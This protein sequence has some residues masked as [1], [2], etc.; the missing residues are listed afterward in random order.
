MSQG[1]NRTILQPGST[2]GVL[3]SGQLGRMFA[4]AA[5][6]LGYRILVFSPDSDSPTGQIA[7]HEFSCHYDDLERIREF[8][9]QVQVITF[10]FENV[11]AATTEA[12]AAIVPVRPSGHV[13]HVT[14][15]RLREK[16]FLET[17]SFPVTP[18]RRINSME[19][20]EKA[21]REVG[22]PAVL[23]TASFG[24]DGK[25]QQKI[26]ASSELPQ[27]F[28]NLRGA[29]GIYEGFVDFEKELS[30]IVARTLDG[31]T[32]TFPVFE[33]SHVNH[34]LDVT[35]APAAIEPPLAAQAR[36]LTCG[37]VE[38]LQV[39]GLLTVE[40]FLTRS[41]KLLV[42]ELA[43]RTHN[44]GH[45]TIDA[46]ITS[47]FEQQ[48]RA[49]CGLPLGATDLRAPAAMANLLGD[50]WQ[51][52]P[53]KWYAALEDPAIKLHLYGKAEARLGRKMGHLTATASS[54]AEAVDKVVRARKRLH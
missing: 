13:L 19:D 17:N 43:P 40:M 9:K 42:N 14:Q 47:Q 35:F 22:I 29:E 3:G 28:A 48:V 27:A 39:V 10:E 18:F 2:I 46:C 21:A 45:L 8:A 11:P 23:K 26:R 15:Q 41:G 49:V 50:V 16:S 7:D 1:A 33:N 30:V 38:K 31:Q 51:D 4:L 25:G 37:I 32:S 52:G 36:D 20:L 53:P 34:I 5:R 54:T 24:Y 12:A 44:S 6:E